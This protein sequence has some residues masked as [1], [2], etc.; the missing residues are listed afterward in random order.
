MGTPSANLGRTEAT[1]VKRGQESGS[2]SLNI[3][4]GMNARATCVIWETRFKLGTTSC[5][6]PQSPSET[7]DQILRYCVAYP[8]RYI[9]YLKEAACTILVSRMNTRIPSIVKDWRLVRS[10]PDK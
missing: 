8:V 9:T 6:L 3:A 5:C 2:T 1:V 10:M 7:G 4:E